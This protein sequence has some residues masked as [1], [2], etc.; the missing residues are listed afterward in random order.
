MVMG[1]GDGDGG[2][3]LSCGFQASNEVTLLIKKHN[4]ICSL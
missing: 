1:I 2:F 3:D 4:Q